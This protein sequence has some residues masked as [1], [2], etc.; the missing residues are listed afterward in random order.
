[1]PFFMAVLPHFLAGREAIMAVMTELVWLIPLGFAVGACGTLIGAGGGFL[2]M[3]ILLLAYPSDSPDLLTAISLAVVFFNALSGSVA[4]GRQRRIDYRSGLLM[5][6]SA[7]PGAVLGALVTGRLPR[8]GFD[9]VLGGLLVLVAVF[10]LGRPHPRAR[11]AADPGRGGGAAF[12]DPSAAQR[13]GT[14]NPALALALSFGVGFISSLVGVGGGIIHVPAMVHLLGFPVHV[15]T[16]TSHFILVLTALVGTGVHMAQ[17]DL[18]AGATRLA[19]LSVGAV[20]G[21]QLGARLSTR[22]HG[23]WIL[24]GLA[25]ALGLVGIRVLLLAL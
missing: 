16:A 14:Y 9:L 7:L 10:L 3:P 6:A 19:A 17:S 2:L 18:S 12:L 4:Y 5:S 13:S 24:R 11:R 8:Q 20:F 15:A 21:A 25:V 23:P 22:I 1:M